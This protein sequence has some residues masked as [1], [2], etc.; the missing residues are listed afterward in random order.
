MNNIHDTLNNISWLIWPRLKRALN[1]IYVNDEMSRKGSALSR[2]TIQN[3]VALLD[4][5]GV[6]LVSSNK[7]ILS[8]MQAF[9][10]K[11]IF[12]SHR[13]RLK[14]L[15]CFPLGHGLLQKSLKPFVGLTG[16]GILVKV[17]RAY[18]KLPQHVQL[19]LLDNYLAEVIINKK[20]TCSKD[21]QPF[22]ILGLPFF[23]PDNTNESFYENGQYFR[24]GYRNSK[25]FVW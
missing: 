8:D 21:L 4:E 25:V 19:K 20:I 11:N 9:R 16:N 17:P 10:W 12:W 15:L 18:F 6:V 24:S 23:H 3:L 7:S 5:D 14:E 1:E 2:T 13:D 22:P